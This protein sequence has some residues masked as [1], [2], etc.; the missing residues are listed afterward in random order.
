MFGEGWFIFVVMRGRRGW[1]R[2]PVGGAS[3]RTGQKAIPCT[4][5]IRGYLAC[6]CNILYP[7]T[8][9][10][11]STLGTR[12]WKGNQYV[13]LGSKVAKMVVHLVGVYTNDWC[14]D[15]AVFGAALVLKY[16]FGR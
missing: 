16:V 9:T 15:V 1:G 2:G 11:T 8:K 10:D 6:M 14:G 5:I 13:Y 4:R 12:G 7:Q 3:D